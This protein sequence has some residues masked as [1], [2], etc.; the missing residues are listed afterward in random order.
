MT[1]LM[2]Q[3]NKHHS[4]RFLKELCIFKRMAIQPLRRFYHVEVIYRRYSVVWTSNSYEIHAPS[5]M[6]EWSSSMQ[7]PLF[8]LQYGINY[9]VINGKCCCEKIAVTK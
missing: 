6:G 3:Y 8:S 1:T 7:N 5:K 2:R 9:K 4:I